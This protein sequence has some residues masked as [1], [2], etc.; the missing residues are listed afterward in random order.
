[1]KIRQF[2]RLMF[3]FSQPYCCVRETLWDEERGYSSQNCY[4][5]L[6]DKYPC[7]ITVE[8]Y[9]KKR[10]NTSS[11]FTRKQSAK[12]SKQDQK[13][14][15][16]GFPRS[17]PCY[18]KQQLKALQTCPTWL[19]RRGRLQHGDRVQ[20]SG[21]SYIWIRLFVFGGSNWKRNDPQTV[22]WD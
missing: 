19:W 3:A 14:T 21:T 15:Q 17:L 22:I 20:S 5:C 8:V 11:G 2:D 1:M 16:S 4:E 12:D 18:W 10:K 13:R 9:N 6:E 7:L